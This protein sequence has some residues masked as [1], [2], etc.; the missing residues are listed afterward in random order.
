MIRMLRT[1]MTTTNAMTTRATIRPGS[2]ALSSAVGCPFRR[3]RKARVPARAPS[4]G[5]SRMRPDDGGRAA[6]LHHL[7]GAAD[8]HDLSR[9][10]RLGGPLLAAQA[11][12]AAVLV[13]RT[14]HD[15]V[16]A[17]QRLDAGPLRGGQ[18]QP[19]LG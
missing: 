9:V 19:P 18:I 11:H 17:L 10:V 12:P 6:D 8:R 7:H 16:A 5:G 3:A 4:V 14:D 15:C 1:R 2:I 13:D